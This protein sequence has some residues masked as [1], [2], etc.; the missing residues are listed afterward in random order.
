MPIIIAVAKASGS[1]S[2]QAVGRSLFHARGTTTGSSVAVMVPVQ[3]FRAYGAS[4]AIAIGLWSRPIPDTLILAPNNDISSSICAWW[5]ST[6]PLP[7]LTSDGILWYSEAP[8][9]TVLPYAVLF[10]IAAVPVA[11]TTSYDVFHS[12]YQLSIYTDQKDSAMILGLEAAGAFDRKNIVDDRVNDI[13]IQTQSGDVRVEL[14]KGLGPN[15]VDAWMGFFNIE[16][17]YKA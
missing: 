10:L 8:V 6:P 9:G 1:S 3:Q 13:L 16:A 12:V 7:S 4:Y 11:R 15:G 17:F 14:A 5:A 2:A